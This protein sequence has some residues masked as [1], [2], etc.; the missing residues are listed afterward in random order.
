M[1]KFGAHNDGLT[2]LSAKPTS[3]KLHE[4]LMPLSIFR[5]CRMGVESY[6]ATLIRRVPTKPN[7]P[8][9]ENEFKELGFDFHQQEA[10]SVFVPHVAKLR[11]VDMRLAAKV[12]DPAPRPI[13]VVVDGEDALPSHGYLGFC[14]ASPH[15]AIT[16]VEAAAKT[17]SSSGPFSLDAILF[18]KWRD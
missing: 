11:L 4:R 12:R 3:N 10:I 7:C 17:A 14:L 5:K 16:E 18:G 15:R 2:W 8:I 6:V 9:F 13:I 1:A